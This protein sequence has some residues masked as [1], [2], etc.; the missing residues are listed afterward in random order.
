MND[1]FLDK[2]RN[3]N[4]YIPRTNTNP[5]QY[6]KDYVKKF[7]DHDWTIPEMNLQRVSMREIKQTIR[8][9]KNSNTVG[10]DDIS[11]TAIKKLCNVIAPCMKRLVAQKNQR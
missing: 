5:L 11:S 8:S 3:I 7:T 6:T 10:H 9:L 4:D 1:F 2:I